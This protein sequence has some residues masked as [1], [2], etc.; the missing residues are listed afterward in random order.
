MEQLALTR[1]STIG[2]IVD[3]V[4]RGGGSV[5]RVFSAAEL[6]LR[7][8]ER[9]DALVP[10]R[11]QFKLVEFAARELGDDALPARLATSAGIAGLGAYGKRFIAA[12]SLG[13]AIGMGNEII[14]S[15]LQ[16]A[17]RMT[18]TVERGLARWTYDVADPAGVGR[19]KNAILATGYIVDLLRRFIG[20]NWA[21]TRTEVPGAPLQGRAAIEALYRCEIVSGDQVAVSFPADFL[22]IPNPAPAH[23]DA[24]E[25]DG[26][27]PLT[28]DLC[29]GVRELIR[30]SLLD[31]RPQRAWVARRLNVSVR[32]LQ[33]RLREHGTSFAEAVRGIVEEQAVEL[34]R[35]RNVSIT[36][37]AY[38]LG[39]SDPAHFTRAF[40]HWFGEPPQLW[41]RRQGRVMSAAMHL[42]GSDR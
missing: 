38:E 17:T 37:I 2:P 12:P 16:S 22:E 9:P 14:G 33:R 31:K 39:Y 10:L 25:L 5:D 3:I 32:T 40:V 26:A 23:D 18:L 21:P 15:T 4:D 35:C 28:G 13:A 1:A 11:D 20:T 19:Q 30:L 41:R 34:L 36:E 27:L 29:A 7:L 42:P 6:P 24:L 8:S